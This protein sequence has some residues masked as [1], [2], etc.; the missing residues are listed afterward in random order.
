MPA[1]PS[2]GESN[3]DHARFCLACGS[4]LLTP[5]R[6]SRR[7][8]TVLFCDLADSTA[9][10]E[11]LDPEALR[12]VLSRYYEAARG[13]LERHGGMVEKFVGDAVM[14]VFGVPVLHED[15]ALRAVRAAAALLERTG[16]VNDDLEREYG[17]RLTLR[18][19][20]NTGDVITG[21]EER[22]A[23]G[24][25]VNVAARLE[26]SAGANEILLGAETFALVRSAVIADPVAPLVVKGK[27]EPLSAWRLVSVHPESQ[28]DRHF[29]VPMVGR[30]QELRRLVESFERAQRDRRCELVTILGPAGVG[31]SR[32][33]HEFLASLDWPAVVRGRCIPYGDGITYLPVIE[34]VRQLE[35]RLAELELDEGVIGTLQSLLD[36]GESLHSTEEIS[37]AVR[38]LLEAAARTQPLV[39]VFDDIQWAAP[40]LLELLEQ[41]AVL[42]HEAPLLL[43]CIAR[44][45]LK[46]RHPG[47][48]GAHSEA[49][50]IVLEP[51]S[52]GETGELIGHLAGD[53]ALTE[54]LRRRVREAAEG[55]PLFVEEMIAFLRDAPA[56]EVAVPGTIAALLG[57]RLDQL[58]AP[59]REVLQRGAVE[60]RVFHRGVVQALGADQAQIGACLTALVRKELI[61]PDRPQFEGEDAFRFRHLLIRDAAYD[62]LPKEARAELHEQLADW[63]EERRSELAEIDELV[64]HHLEQAYAYRVQLRRVDEHGRCLALR[65]SELLAGAGARALGRNDVGA[66]V[67]L[68]RRALVLRDE[69]DPA[70]ALRL[71]LG[72]ALFLSGDLHAAAE[73]SSEA[74]VCAAAAQ[75][76]AG[77]LRA[78]LL[79]ARVAA[80]TPGEDTNGGGPSAELLAVA[81]EARV[82]FARVG[83]ELGLA[84]AWFATAWAEL[85]RCRW[86]AM[87]EAS[88]HALDHARRGGS[89]RW[90][91]ELPVWQGTAMF[92]GPTPT[93]EALRW[94]EEQRAQHPV[95]LTQHAIL[96]AMRG[97]FDRA[98]T[99]AASADAAAAEFG[100]KLWLAAGGMSL[101]EIE[102]LAGD[103]S[104]AERAVRQSCQLLG[105]LGE[106]G[107]RSTAAGQLAA[108]LYALARLD[109]AHEWTET[110]EGLAPKGDVSSQMLWRQVRARV[111]ARRGDHAEAVELA[112]QA[113]LLAEATDMLNYHANALADLGEIYVAAGRAGE[114]RAHLEQ[115][116]A[117]YEQ[118]GNL[119]A[120]DRARRRL[121]ELE[122]YKAPREQ[123]RRPVRIARR[124]HQKEGS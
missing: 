58:E 116:I 30:G 108:S 72:Q 121:E 20:V 68:L 69:S 120:A 26:Q 95:S 50:T 42:S 60:G 77:E 53:E 33:A 11:R 35:P 5:D 112:R 29:D 101:W 71:D 74:A 105:E 37:F 28:L 3:P 84:E 49:T 63:L 98:R 7:R 78:R 54:D 44:P 111:L 19:G 61:R 47:W 15:D 110:A 64:G 65:A 97:N 52:S 91:G 18:I 48:V 36:A 88:R 4:P 89:A 22:L 80:Q 70:V 117:L 14:A 75:D 1:C 100:Q 13:A 107:H 93:D 31:K 67:K 17:T 119:V 92:H 2:C 96:E 102:M 85:I 103:L 27:S 94:F 81:E 40:A 115:A 109:E 25:A 99:L 114:G 122:G 9:M 124:G 24:D 55:N 66:A 73:T 59:E 8:V 76:E 46:E 90:E 45:D 16:R 118:K 51:L 32:L 113:V 38:R 23:V 10:G 83:D 57:A 79:R 21:T 104:A 82:V 6:E 62:S 43:C 86:A 106:V 56:G 34:V 39:C 41:L 123:T 87:L 12:R